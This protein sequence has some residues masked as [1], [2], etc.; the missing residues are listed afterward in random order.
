MATF[1]IT[2]LSG[3]K[4]YSKEAMQALSA[5]ISHSVSPFC[6]SALLALIGLYLLIIPAFFLN[7]TTKKE[8][9]TAT[10]RY[11][12]MQALSTEYKT[13]KERMGLLD[14]RKALTKVSS[15]TQA[16][17]TILTSIGLKG[18]MKSLKALGSRELGGGIEEN[19]ELYLEKVTM[20]ELVN[21]FYSLENAPMAIS[22]KKTTM[23]KSFEKPELLDITITISLFS[24]N[25]P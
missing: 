13:L 24:A 9:A 17:D 10:A 19:A 18:R 7:M 21:I 12:E 1:K 25:N 22:I 5:F 14:K 23:K 4:A 15:I 11:K 8:A 16:S 2:D 3:L 20:N 6:W